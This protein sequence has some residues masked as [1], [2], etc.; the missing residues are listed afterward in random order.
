MCV[1]L[2]SQNNKLIEAKYTKSY[3]ELQSLVFIPTGVGIT[4]DLFHSEYKD[5]GWHS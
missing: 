1:Q 3:I 2:E 4:R 5:T